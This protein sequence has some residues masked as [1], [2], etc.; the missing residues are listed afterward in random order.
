MRFRPPLDAFC[1]L[2]LFIAPILPT[3][4]EKPSINSLP[5]S[6]DYLLRTWDTEDG[7]PSND[8][9]SIT[10]TPD[11]YLWVATSNGLA[12]FDG[13]QFTAFPDGDAH[14]PPAHSQSS[15]ALLTA[16]DGTLWA[17]IGQ[18]GLARLQ[19]EHLQF[20]LPSHPDSDNQIVSLTEDTDGAIWAGFFQGDTATRWKPGSIASF[21]PSAQPGT[22]LA[23][24]TATNGVIWF[25]TYED[26]GFFDGQKFRPLPIPDRASMHLGIARKGGVW[27]V[28][29]NQLL[30]LSDNGT[31]NIV[32]QLPWLEKSAQATV[33]HED[34][35]GN[36]WIGTLGLG[37]F[38]FR[39]GIFEHVSTSFPWI[40]SLYEDRTGNLWVGTGGGGLNRLSPRRFFI[41]SASI[42]HSTSPSG[43]RNTIVTSL[44]ADHEGRLWMAQGY[45]LV[46]ATDATNSTFSSPQG[47]TESNDSLISLTVD[48][49]DNLWLGESQPSLRC[50]KDGKFLSELSLPGSLASFL[51]G[52]QN[53]LWVATKKTNPGLYEWHNGTFELLST[54]GSGITNP[55]CM[56]FDAQK[57]LWVGTADGQVFYR[58]EKIFTKTPIP[59]SKPGDI[60]TFLVPD[61][62]NTIW[63]G[64]RW[65]GLYRWH[66][67]HL[68][69]MPPD[70]NF[71]SGELEALNIEPDGNFW[72]GTGHGLIRIA[73]NDLEDAMDG[74]KHGPLP[75]SAYGRN[76]GLPGIL[77]FHYGFLHSTARTPDGHLWFG[78]NL[79]ALEIL[80]RR[81][82]KATLPNSIFIEALLADGKPF[83]ISKDEEA[84]S[85][86][87][88][89]GTIQF[90]YTLPQL[91]AP[92][93][94]RFRYRLLGSQ[95]ESWYQADNQR[96]ATF[97]SLPQ[98]HYVFEVSATDPSN[99][100][101][102][103]SATLTFS[104]RPAWWETLWFRLG[105]ILI[106][107]L[108]LA[109]LV[110]I[111]VKR[112][113]LAYIRKLE[114]ANALERE[115]ARI[116]RDMHDE[117]GT[118]LTHVVLMSEAA[119]HTHPSAD[120][121]QIAEA[122]RTV[123]STLDQIVWT[124]TPSNDTLE[125]LISYIAE[126]A[127]GYLAISDTKLH[128][129][130]PS[131]IPERPLSSEKRH[132]LVLAVK[133]AFNNI[134]KYAGAH[135]V[136]LRVYFERNYLC[137]LIKDDGKGFDPTT[138][139]A[140][141]NGLTNMRY[142]MESI[143][144]RAKIESQPGHG[145]TVIFSIKI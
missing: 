99:P 24:Y 48:S 115:R 61:G 88:H 144:G 80:P 21:Q 22:Y 20:V 7:L 105:G 15:T 76:D 2:A 133:E 89:P 100:H 47:W 142:R 52:P 13:V 78:T 62:T 94:L 92:E 118:S 37:L 10:Q 50:W 131:E 45:A 29:G 134:I 55:V 83:P 33:L 39:D 96:I 86:P 57:R 121:R 23:L 145:T 95:D 74:R 63:I 120:L 30:R 126:F 136:Q 104:V 25:S 14:Q 123:S 71:P 130:L 75:I 77:E 5:N 79:G 127:E 129:E 140:T 141:S 107:A 128:M 70:S 132:H 143:G 41:R 59:E 67:G 103:V 12:R 72:F 6:D 91:D 90:R 26:C 46:Q 135:T 114:Q 36:L 44:S 58:E 35:D 27:A 87:P 65:S 43:S 113:M 18:G 9:R 81:S 108:T 97:S 42:N 73:R 3:S 93:E 56:A 32:A 98:G 8:I 139:A 64:R 66:A 106:A 4:A 51:I 53:Q 19:G 101:P 38:R 119:A 124:T 137:I 110:R 117:L 125:H 40:Q 116:A 11:G 85:L 122:T 16:R 111:A 28:R 82:F 112:R 54:I 17:A 68:D 69:N 49:A 1:V 31:C 60:V 138:I 84:I 102:S 109:A 34:H